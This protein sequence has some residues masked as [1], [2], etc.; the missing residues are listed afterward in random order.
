M[1]TPK[2]LS[3]LSLAAALLTVPPGLAGEPASTLDQQFRTPPAQARPHVWWHWMNGNVD[4]DGATLDLEWMKRA[5][6]GGVQIFE[7]NLE[8]AQLVPERL[9]YMSPAWKAAL[10]SA[11]AKAQEL[12]LEVAIA[13]SPG[14]SATG[15]PWVTPEAAMKKLVWSAVTLSGNRTQIGRAHV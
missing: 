4:A 10:R 13:S 6:I 12:G 5:G 8:T 3:A 15:G 14:W 9:I 11:V 2:G 1:I 7:G